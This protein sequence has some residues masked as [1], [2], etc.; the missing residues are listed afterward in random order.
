[1][2]TYQL[3]LAQAIL[4]TQQALADIPPAR[5]HLDQEVAIEIKAGPAV[6]LNM[7]DSRSEVLGTGGESGDYDTLRVE[8]AF[9]LSVYTR[10][11]PHTQVADPLIQQVHQ[12]L[13]ADPSLGGLATRLAFRGIRA[14][15]GA[16]DG[17]VGGMDLQ[18]I[19]TCCVDERTLQ[20][21]GP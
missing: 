5:V 1:M 11:A 10:G 21:I 2:A 13:M 7:G 15:R 12:A 6:E 17:A 19:A 3:Q 14:R 18:Y 4:A 16:A 20:I 9:A 8:Q